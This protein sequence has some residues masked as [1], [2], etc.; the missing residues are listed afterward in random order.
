MSGEYL[1]FI[2]KESSVMFKTFTLYLLS[3]CEF[4]EGF[5]VNVFLL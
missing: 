1:S 3:Y 2:S 4:I 5:T